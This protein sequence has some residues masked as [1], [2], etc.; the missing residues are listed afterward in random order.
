[1]DP[2]KTLPADANVNMHVNVNTNANIHAGGDTSTP[3][4]AAYLSSP[5]WVVLTA[6]AVPLAVLPSGL[7]RMAM[8]VGIPVGWSGQLAEDWQ[9]GLET[10]SYIT[11][12]TIVTETLA[13]LTIGLVSQW[14]E[15]VPHWIPFLGGKHIPVGAA[16]VP[17]AL[18]ALA[19]TAFTLPMFWGGMPADAGGSDAPQ[20]VAAWIM[21]AC[22]V[23]LLLWG[24]MVAVLTVAYTRRRL[25]TA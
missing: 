18:G 12:L 24:P 11:L 9:P 15:R 17:A 5:R 4:D 1:M 19:V 3:A 14:G 8:A 22:Y 2:A 20:G 25:R 21:N 10:S 6:R 16:V 7:W 13:F 23:P